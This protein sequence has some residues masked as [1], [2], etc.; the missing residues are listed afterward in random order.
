MSFDNIYEAEIRRQLLQNAEI[1]AVVINARDSMFLIGNVDLYVNSADEKKAMIVLQQFQGL[2]K[3]NSF[4]IRKPIELFQKILEQNN[5]TTVLKEKESYKYILEN[6]ELYV[7]NEQ[8]A[9]VVPFL[10]G[11]NL[12][13]WKRVEVCQKVRQTQYK[14]QLLEDSDIDSIVIKKRDSD[15]HLEDITI[16]VKESNFEKATEILTK[17]EGWI[18]V[19]SYK[20]PEV[21]ELKEDILAKAGLKAIIVNKNNQEFEI[22][23]ENEHKAQAEGILNYSKQWVELRKCN[24]LVEAENITY[25]L[26]ENKIDSSILTLKD[27]MFLVGG[28][29]IYV[30][31]HKFN[32]AFEILIQTEGGTIEE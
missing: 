5:I 10:S 14:V 23:V 25:I 8:A 16:Y 31:K 19:Q 20:K 13:G 27:S 32:D 29:S 6:F 15:F 2:T 24:N 28:Y 21:A 30:E 7:P 4:I 11:E 17:L 3:V 18:I 22:L 12:T 26:Q 9:L 1:T